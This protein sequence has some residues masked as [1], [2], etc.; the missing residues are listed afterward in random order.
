MN[1][2]KSLALLILIILHSQFTFAQPSNDDCNGAIS[3]TPAQSCITTSGDLTGSTKSVLTP[4]NSN[5]DIWYKFVAT[6]SI[7]YITVYSSGD[8]KASL[9]VYSGNCGTLTSIGNFAGTT[10]GTSATVSGL[11][12]GQTYYY[13]VYHNATTLPTTKKF[14]T[15]VENYILNNDCS[16]ATE[17]IPSSPGELCGGIRAR[18][19]AAT[20][21]SVGCTGTA[22]DDVWF[23]FKAT[24]TTHF[25]EV[26]GDVSFNAVLQF[27]SGD[28]NTLSSA[29]CVNNTAADGIEST[30]QTGL[31]VG[32]WYYVRVYDF[33]NT[34]STTPYFNI[35]VT[36][37]PSND[38]CSNAIEV[39]YGNTCTSEFTDGTYANQSLAASA[40]KGDANDDVWFKFTPDTTVAFISIQPSMDYDPVVQLFSACGTPAT[41]VSTFYDDNSY[42]K[43]VFGTAI[44][45]GLTKGTTYYYRVYDKSSII[46]EMMSFTTCVVRPAINDE[47]N[48]ATK[49]TA[50]NTCQET[51]GD[52]TYATESTPATGGKGTA[53]D[54][55][56]YKFTATSNS[57]FITVNASLEYNPV[58]QLF[59]GC[60]TPAT[61]ASTFY[62]DASFPIG[63]SYTAKINGLTVGNT[64]YY[65]VYDK[66]TTNPQTMTFT[67][68]VTT[69]PSN[70]DCSNATLLYVN[71]TCDETTGNGTYAT[72]SAE[73]ACSGGPNSNND[74]VWYKFTATSANA[75]I[76]VSPDDNQY[77]PIVQVFS[78]C[79]TPKAP[80]FCED[81]LYVK[82]KFGTALVQ[83][84]TIG[85]TYY[86]RIY[87]KA[88]TNQDTMTFK[89]C[90]VS[91]VENDDC[92]GA[93]NVTVGNTCNEVISDGMYAI[94]SLVNGSC[95]TSANDDIWFKFTATNDSAFIS[96][97]PKDKNYDPVVELFN[98]CPAT[99]TPNLFCDD[100][101]F[102]KGK[103]GTRAIT[104]LTV[105]NT[106]Y[107]RIY[108]KDATNEDTMEVSTCVV[109]P[110]NND[111]CAGA[112]NITPSSSCNEIAGDG[113]YATQSF[114]QCS[115]SNGA[116]TDDV[117]FKFTATTSKENISI[118]S[119]Q[120]YDPVIEVY[121]GCNT[122]IAP[123]IC[124]DGNF[125]TNGFGTLSINTTPS[126]T[127]YYRVYDKNVT[128]TYPLSFTTCVAHAPSN[129]D[130]SGAITVTSGTTCSSVDGEGTYATKSAG[131]ATTCGGNDTDDV[132]YKFIATNSSQTIYVD[133]S[134]DYN[135]VVQLYSNCSASPTPFPA[136]ATS[137]NDIR[138]PIGGYGSNTFTG[139][140]VGNTYYYRVY[141]SGNTIPSPLKF[142]TCVTNPPTT[143][144]NDNP[145]NAIF[146]PASLNCN[147]QTFTNEA[148]TGSSGI[149]TPSCGTLSPNDVWF[150]TVIP[151]SGEIT[152]DSKELTVVD[153]ALAVYIG[154]CNSLSEIG[155]DNNSGTNNMPSLN[156][157]NLT[158]GDT[159]WIRFWSNNS[160][161]TGSFGLCI[162][163]PTEAPL[164][165]GCSNLSF[166]NST[167][168]WFG[169]TGDVFKLA[170]IVNVPTPFYKSTVRN[171]GTGL[172]F[173][174]MT[175]G[176]DPICGFPT[177]PAGYS[178]SL[179]LGDGTVTGSKGATIEQYFTV[180]KSN[181]NFVYNYAV[182]FNAERSGSNRHEPYQQP[183]FKVEVFDDEG[184]QI[185]C[186]DYL[187]GA[188]SEPG[189]MISPTSS[190]VT[191]KPWTKVSIDLTGY[192]GK[193]VHVRYT[194]GDCTEGGHYGYAYLTCNCAPFEITKPT[195]V[196]I[197]DTAKLYGPKGAQNYVWKD[198]SGTVV[199][200]KDSLYVVTSVAGKFKYT[201]DVTMFGTSM[202]ENTLEAEIEVGAAPTISITNPDTVCI[203]N[204][205]DLTNTSITA[206]SS[207]NLVYTYW[208]DATATTPLTN[209]TAVNTSGTYYI[210]GEKSPT[211]KDVKPVI[212]TINPIP[213][214]ANKTETIC[215]DGTFSVTPTNTLP[216]IVPTGTKYKWTVVDN[217]NVTGESN[218]STGQVVISQSLSNISN[219][220]QNVVYTVTP[221]TPDCDG[222]PFTVTVTINPMPKIADKTTAICSNNSFDVSPTN[223]SPDIVPVGTTYTWTFTDNT[224][225]T[226][227]A[228]STTDETSVKSSTNLINTTSAVQTVDYIVTPKSGSCIGSTFKVTVSINPAPKVPD[229]AKNICTGTAFDATPIDNGTTTLIPLGT[230]YSWS[231]PIVTGGVTGSSAQTNVS[232]ISQ[233]L[234]NPDATNQTATFGI[235]ANSN[236]TPNC[237]STFNAVITVEPKVQPVISCGNSNAT[238][239]EFTWVDIPSVTSYNFEY[240]I[241]ASGALTTTASIPAGSTSKTITGLS[242][243]NS[244]YFTLTPVGIL[245]PLPATKMC[246]NCSQPTITN[247]NSLTPNDFEICVGE[248]ITLKSS[249]I[250]TNSN[251]WSFSNPE[252]LNITYPSSKD[253]LVI[254]GKVSG[255]TDVTFI[256]D[257]GCATS[258][259]LKINQTPLI[260]DFAKSFCS[261][262]VI[263]IIPDNTI[264]T[265]PNGTYYTWTVTP[266]S[267]ISGATS[268]TTPKT[269]INQTLVNSSNSSILVT[270]NVNAKS[271]ISPNQCSSNFNI[272]V[273]IIPIPKI[274]NIDTSICTGTAFTL[275]PTNTISGNVVPSGTT[276][277][278]T[279]TPVNGITGNN[280]QTVNQNN[281]SEILTNTSSTNLTITYDI[282]AKASSCTNTFKGN[283]T[284]IALPKIE[285]K[286][287]VICSEQQFTISPITQGNDIVP[288]GTTYTW[289]V[290]PV[291]GLTGINNQSTAQNNISETI[292]NSTSNQLIAKYTVTASVGTTPTCSSTF[293]VDISVNPKPS[294]SQQTQSICS[295]NSF[296]ITPTDGG[297]NIV[298]S[299]T[300]FTW[301]SPSVTNITGNSDESTD[302]STISQALTNSTS[303]KIDVNYTVTASS[304]FSN[305]TCTNTFPIVISVQPKP[306][307]TL[308]PIDICTGNSFSFAPTDGGGNIVPTGTTYTWTVIQEPTVSGG[309]DVSSAQ[310][311][312]SQVLSTSDINTR[313]AT[314]T[315]L[316]TSN[317]TPSCSNTFTGVVNVNPQPLISTKNLTICS[318]SSFTCSPTTTNGDIV[319]SGTKYTWT[320]SNVAG[321]SGNSDETIGQSNVSQTLTNNTNTPITASYTVTGTVGVAPN[322]CTS[323]F[324]LNVTVNPTP[325]I[326]DKTATICSGE[327]FNIQ[328]TDN[329]PSEIVPTNTLYTWTVANT[330][331]TSGASSVS[332][333]TNTI[334]QSITNTQ[335]SPVILNYAITAS[336]GAAPT[337]CTSNFTALVTINPLPTFTPTATSQCENDPLFLQAN[338]LTATQVV[339]SSTTG[340]SNT[341]SSDSK[342]QAVAKASST[343]DGTYTVEVTD[344]NGCKKSNSVVVKINPLPTVSAGLD[345]A[346]CIGDATK[347]AGS[348]AASYSWNNGVTD[349]TPFSP[350]STLTYTVTGTDVKG[351]KN[352]DDIV[353]TVNTLPTV[354]AGLDKAIC[355]GDNITLIGAGAQTFTWNNGVIDNIAFSPNTTL[356]YI[357]T[358]TDVNG[359]KNNDTVKVT[360][361]SLPVFTPTATSQC[362]NDPLY[363]QAHFSTATNV[364]WN[365]PNGYTNTSTS[366]TKLQAVAKA[367]SIDDGTY[368]VEVTDANGCKKIE[369]ITVKINLLPNVSAG[370]D[371]SICIGSSLS[372][373]ASGADSYQWDN[374]ITNNVSF[375]PTITKDYIVV[376]TDS[377]GCKNS[378]TVKV[379]VNSLPDF[380]ISVNDPCE[381]QDLSFNVNLSNNTSTIGVLN[382]DWVGPNGFSSTNLNPTINQVSVGAQGKY[383]LKITDNNQCVKSKDIDAFINLVDNIQYSDVNPK[384]VNDSPFFLPNPNIQGGTWSSDDNTSIQNPYTGLFDPT[385]SKP[386]QEYK[387]VVTYSTKTINPPRKCPSTKSK[388]IFVN[389][390]PDST[391]HAINP[392]LC[393]DD[394]LFL[395]VNKPI[396][397]IN[398]TW[399]L[400]NGVTKTGDTLMYVY[401]ND[402]DFTIKLTSTL[403]N[404]KVS[405]TLEDYIHIIAKPSYVDFT[406]SDIE[407]DFYN[408][409]IQFQSYT[410]G[411]YLFWNFGDGSHS[412]Y[413]NPKHKFPEI[414]GEYLIEL[415]ASNM[416]NNYCSS[417]VT[418]SIFMPE[419]VIYFIP[420]TFTP[421]G[422][423]LNNVFQP[424]FT[425][426]YDPQHYSFYIYNRWGELIF[427]S[428]NPKIGWD[429]TYGDKVVQ[430]DTYIWKLEFK[431]KIQEFKH[432]KTGHVNVLR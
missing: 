298:P 204:T 294:I 304:I 154:N 162:T 61:G 240:K 267:G 280:D 83:N 229:F 15:C 297:G 217:P 413:K 85:N 66:E 75:F 20:Q 167:S 68:C 121:T 401:P 78:A 34:P 373:Q 347:L 88:T 159:L 45:K 418:R 112:I 97:T 349:N 48:N 394:T 130:C 312:I 277:T 227:E 295:E 256:N 12:V 38:D 181:A 430:N 308:N 52:G 303:S 86:Y 76:S 371:K 389:P 22:D 368:T 209:Q 213:T 383:T 113:T 329:S 316:A 80:A 69:A 135:P 233:T 44:V 218:Q 203:P 169:T 325:K 126:T 261:E 414:P 284:V 338:F 49:I 156:L 403:G 361:N 234:T 340:Y 367:S 292:T 306:S 223:T 396:K 133:A 177:V 364:I 220:V 108:D 157:K 392:V 67:T 116:A 125:P 424:I 243:G 59:S 24:N 3:I 9:Q 131:T 354:S 55:V 255:N 231:A 27:Y 270:Y 94:Q 334:S 89:T 307:I 313:K 191:Y 172:F 238:S 50:G 214:I 14:E 408:P 286:A 96:V 197:G 339:W 315:V 237:S 366:D 56:W 429:G 170:G 289:T 230:T 247:N 399:D 93:L 145:C 344:A 319:P 372:L 179:R 192:I 206:G 402:G 363:L 81:N 252:F 360:V 239:M 333:G 194:T 166:Q 384:C 148:A 264:N 13:R 248:T 362:E 317:S 35:C 101:L 355:I 311:S 62:D 253:Q 33:T 140:T 77:D 291:T 219:T 201:L 245:C 293:K 420:N 356:D 98:A 23:K 7:H 274:K 193:A 388:V 127:Y 114:T 142:S 198:P 265:I 183:F 391:F 111:N 178:S 37:P 330:S 141:D 302:Q 246:S 72:T 369:N 73:S 100:N 176:V 103:F 337:I 164:V 211:C 322:I 380:T 222:Q 375:S 132:W 195:K 54:D 210:K 321:I 136:I 398:Y 63:D 155:C 332:V 272:L 320:T 351:C 190:L 305:V 161:A 160:T 254:Q 415:T 225:I 228:N 242:A 10:V 235:T 18:T 185:S 417:T 404:C 406:Q 47:C 310:N 57:H 262:A 152:I 175:S 200:T 84:L 36:T 341:A 386:D 276:Y 171:I 122:P 95:G 110:V 21:S 87:D 221:F 365:G 300:L 318:G 419:P 71:N 153:G 53:N 390:I 1:L 281:I 342:L 421:N 146:V 359:C 158:P 115:G 8:F 226:N 263:D 348:G 410:N 106:Y 309:N 25:V 196:C 278:W 17:L 180:E 381:Q 215:S 118:F 411:K 165:G 216:D 357:V 65:R 109:N 287:D 428:H 43:G 40:G 327:T 269:Q 241:G 376:G 400:G 326:S 138:Y 28:C 268:E 42:G 273:T 301:V 208:T 259:N 46:N 184:N 173:N 352:T 212:V 314:Y 205:V 128:N 397:T 353:V 139:L 39:K 271:G 279:Q 137:C 144:T 251:Q 250:P 224:N 2:L 236:T 6:T 31:I 343:D 91:A 26:D 41:G 288:S 345:Q 266:P 358:G 409:E 431:E 377:K 328:P 104:G 416:E 427:E 4:T 143:P 202:C 232:V 425:S 260:N 296:S 174:V 51:T 120:F 186:G 324:T 336:S 58:V 90:V 405:E 275:S 163:K 151:F 385:K 134:Q 60:M 379:I 149:S 283:I 412:T 82:G 382:S 150:K 290:L 119:S 102:P 189:F 199:S 285:D 168:S 188:F 70:D 257:N 92:A 407:I 244:V 282:T 79:G 11:T 331:G 19:S 117:W 335:S 346:I 422:D 426:G 350:T 249:E 207:S 99:P 393:I 107:Y 29:A 378:D 323:T 387:V 30:K 124:N 123:A 299:S 182:V 370:N 64:Y 129:D 147:Y 32:N 74:D 374:Q 5:F 105:G 16:G 432:V 423:E 258:I 187:V 395:V